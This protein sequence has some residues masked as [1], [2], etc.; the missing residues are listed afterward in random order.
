MKLKHILTLIC[1]VTSFNAIGQSWSNFN[2]FGVQKSSLG[3]NRLLPTSGSGNVPIVFWDKDTTQSKLDLKSNIADVYTK[4]QSDANF[5][6]L[7]GSYSNPSWITSL[8]YSKITGAPDLSVYEIISNKQNSLSADG[9]NLKYPTVTAVNTGLGLKG[10]LTGGNS[11]SG[12]QSYI[13]NISLGTVGGGTSYGFTLNRTISTINYM[14]STSIS[15]VGGVAMTVNDG[16]NTRSIIVRPAANYPEYSPDNNVTLFEIYHK[17][18][19]SQLITDINLINYELLA[20]KQNSLTADGTNTK[21]PTVTAVNTGLGLKANIASPTFTTKITTPAITLSSAP[22]VTFPAS[23]QLLI[24][25]ASTGDLKGMNLSVVSPVSG[26]YLYYNGSNFV[27]APLPQISASATLDF[28]N[29]LM[30]QNAVLTTTVTGA[31]V[32]DVVALGLPNSILST[33]TAYNGTFQAWVSAT[34]TV[35]IR[36]QNSD[37]MAAHDLASATFKVTVFK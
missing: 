14:A 8:N 16:T 34:N 11:W 2:N 3:G 29:V 27:N 15:A 20:N 37:P 12:N 24:R 22:S 31:A 19:L 6:S 21:Y 32:G 33:M 23:G 18:R 13:G 5:V 25:D 9:T 36:F 10:N 4:V 26:D 17:G 30:N 35:S 28:P 1:L 7:L